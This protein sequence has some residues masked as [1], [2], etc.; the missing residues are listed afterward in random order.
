MHCVL[1]ILVLLHMTRVRFRCV[2]VVGL[3]PQPSENACNLFASVGGV[4]PCS[5]MKQ[6]ITANVG[7][8]ALSEQQGP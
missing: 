7:V 3:A 1:L 2:Q 8:N 6:T 4:S 5:A